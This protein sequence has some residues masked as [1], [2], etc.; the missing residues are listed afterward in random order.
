MSIPWPATLPQAGSWQEQQGSIVV[1]TNPDTGP[2]KTRRRYTKAKRTATTS[3]LMTIPQW[4]TLDSFFENDLQGGA[5][6]MSFL[7]PWKQV[8]MDM[9]ITE[10]PSH[11]NDDSLGVS[12]SMKVEF[13]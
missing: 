1:R 3:F 10:P 11:S 9:Y 8:M 4:Q 5:I 7:H 6:A 12:V 2:A 13:F